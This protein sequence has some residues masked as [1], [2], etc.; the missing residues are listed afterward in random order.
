AVAN[1][2]NVLSSQLQFPE[3]RPVRPI[4]NDEQMKFVR[5]AS[6]QSLESAKQRRCV[7]L[8][9]Q[10]AYVKEQVL[11]RTNP[12]RAPYC[13][14]SGSVGA[15]DFRVNTKTKHAHVVNA[16]VTQHAAQQ[17]R[18]DDRDGV[19]IV[20]FTNVS[21]GKLHHAMCRRFPKEHC[22]PS[23]VRF[24]KM[25]V[26]KPAPRSAE[27][28][29]DLQSFPAE[30]IRIG[31]LDHIR[32]FPVQ[33]FFHCSKI[34]QRAVLRRTRHN[35]RTNRVNTRAPICLQLRLR[36]RNNKDMFV[37][38]RVPIDVTDLLVKISLH[39]AA[40]R[41]IELGEVADLHR[42][43]DFRLPSADFREAAI[44][45]TSSPASITSERI[46]VSPSKPE[47]M[48]NSNQKHVSSASSSTTPILAINSAR[49]RARHAAR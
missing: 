42:I 12:K 25:R 27:G 3:L 43:A 17:V 5:L 11:T 23:H 22:A 41:R 19:L 2:R 48:I 36:A 32:P 34:Q 7:L 47:S 14:V 9:R 28:P 20:E 49:E 1:P 40:Y 44:I 39:A 29:P 15:E 6:L 24:W 16:P 4:A 38:V 31:G 30:L 33:N 8:F 45:A 10:P 35:R 26:I 13:F 18:C 21:A 37:P 46:L